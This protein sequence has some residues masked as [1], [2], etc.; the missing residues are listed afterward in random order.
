M[1]AFNATKTFVLFLYEDNGIQWT[2][3]DNQGGTNG[4]G[5]S[6][7]ARIG[8][9]A[10]DGGNTYTSVLRSLND[11]ECILKIDDF[12]NIGIPGMFLYEVSNGVRSPVT[13]KRLII[14]VLF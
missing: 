9:D 3:G 11:T 6:R 13:G 5:G 12:S 4:L 14:S 2:T 8:F 10:A 1:I 7:P